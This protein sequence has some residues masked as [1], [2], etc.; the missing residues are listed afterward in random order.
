MMT[1]L[2]MGGVSCKEKDTAFHIDL[3][4][5]IE[6]SYT[7]SFE[8]SL[9]EGLSAAGLVAGR[10]YRLKT[11]SAQGDMSTLSMLIDAAESSK[12]DLLITFQAP[13]L[14]TAIQRAPSVNKAFTLLQNPFILGAGQ[15]DADHMA[16]LTGM[17]LVPPFEELFGMMEEC[18]PSIRTVGVIYDSGNDDSVYR[19]NELER[20]VNARGMQLATVPYTAQHEIATAA[21]ALMA[22]HPQA[23]MHLQDPA[24][25]VTF[26]ALFKNASRR[27]LPVFSVVFNMERIGAVIACSTDRKEIGDQ[28][29]QMVVRIVQGADPSLM[30]FENDRA[31]RKRTGYNRTVAA[32][33]KLTLPDSLI[34]PAR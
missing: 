19:K 28:F 12:T 32:D 9:Q 3:V 23:V 26:P 1:V 10:D 25:D 29:A 6:N 13:T 27:K 20:F 24:Q 22:S 7:Q 8:E 2:L 21:E 17:Y 11:R 31:L 4:K 33:I 5:Y 18:K 30:P 16:R 34:N 15:S 14:Y